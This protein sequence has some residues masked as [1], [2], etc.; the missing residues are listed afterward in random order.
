MTSADW[1]REETVLKRTDVTNP[2]EGGAVLCVI[3]KM[4]VKRIDR[5]RRVDGDVDKTIGIASRRNA[6]GCH[7][8]GCASLV[9]H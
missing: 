8:G 6:G 9:C 7:S 5:S 4:S 2:V 3:L 1:R